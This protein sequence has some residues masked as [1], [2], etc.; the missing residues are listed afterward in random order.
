MMQSTFASATIGFRVAS[1]SPWG[2]ALF[3]DLAR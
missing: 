1:S 2:S 3:F